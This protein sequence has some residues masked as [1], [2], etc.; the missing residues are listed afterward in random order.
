MS[1]ASKFAAHF[2]ERPSIWLQE[3]LRA[4]VSDDGRLLLE[5]PHTVLGMSS[6]SAKKLAVF[7]LDTFTDRPEG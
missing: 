7:A 2:R 6:D 3:G 4:S 5:A 1:K